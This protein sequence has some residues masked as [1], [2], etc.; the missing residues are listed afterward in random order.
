LTW[1]L[2]GALVITTVFIHFE[3]LRLLY[4]LIPRQKRFTRMRVAIAVVGCFCAHLVEI[5]VF[6][7]AL[8]MAS[9][10]LGLGSLKGIEGNDSFDNFLYFSIVSYTS[11]GFGDIY[12]VGGLRLLSGVEALL[13]LMMITWSATF[14]FL[15]ME[16]FWKENE[17]R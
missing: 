13:G 3:A 14:A 8:Y 1:I 12:P 9:V 5:I 2:A 17:K 16:K 4:R 15:E 10:Y 7:V 11:L 6:A